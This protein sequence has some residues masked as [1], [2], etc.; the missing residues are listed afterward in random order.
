MRN[1]RRINLIM[2][3]V[4]LTGVFSASAGSLIDVAFTTASATSKTGFAATGVTTNDFWNT[5]TIN[6]GSGTLANFDFVDGS[7]SGAGLTVLNVEGVYGNGASDP[8]YGTY[9]DNQGGDITVTVTGLLAGTYDFYLYGHGNGDNQNSIF[10]ITEEA[11]SYGSEETTNGPGWLS[12]VWQEGVQYVEFTNVSVYAGETMSITVAPGAGGYAV[13]S[14]LQM[15]YV[16][17]L[18]NNPFIA[19]PPTNETAIG[20]SNASFSVV[21]SGPMPLA[22]QWQFEGTNLPAA[23][24]ATLLLS[25]P[26]KNTVSLYI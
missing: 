4:F 7:A 12:S 20:G 11:Q 19:T 6:S 18:S 22:Y 15:A 25:S 26:L 23:T 1:S 13:L 17:P 24:N 9:L 16:G 14:G 10:Q 21:A 2:A 3:A 5:C 8:M